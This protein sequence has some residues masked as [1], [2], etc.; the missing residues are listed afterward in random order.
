M[1]RS[2]AFLIGEIPPNLELLSQRLTE[3]QYQEIER[4][5]TLLGPHGDDLHLQRISSLTK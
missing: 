5:V 2:L 1:Q 3:V 4:G